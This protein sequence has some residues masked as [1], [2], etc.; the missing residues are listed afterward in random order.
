MSEIATLTALEL[1]DA[2]RRGELGAREAAAHFLARIEELNPALGSFVT[3]TAERAM[4]AAAAADERHAAGVA[5]GMLH[6]MPLGYK[7]LL[8]VAGVPTGYGTAAFDPVVPE[9]DSPLVATLSRAGAISLGKTQVP[10]FGLSCHS[11]ND[12]APPARN[13]LDPALSAGGSSGGEA[14]AVASGMLPFG[15]GSDGGGSVRIPA[16]ACGLIGLKPGLGTIPSDVLDGTVDG[17]G[18]PKLTVSGPLARTAL[19]AALLMDAM[20]D[21][22]RET[23]LEALD[24]GAVDALRGLRIGVSTASPFASVYEIRLSAD[25]HVAL[26][27]GIKVLGARGHHLEEAEIFYDAAYPQ[28]FSTV[29]TGGLAAAP[30]PA[31]SEAKLGTLARSF[32][33]R[34]TAREAKTSVE[35][36]RR[37]TQ[38]AA[39][40]R[41][42][43]GR[44]DVVL[45]PAM[46]FAPPE[47]GFYTSQDADTDYMRQC[48]YTPFTSMVNVSGLP[49]ITVPTL[50][51]AGGLSMGVQLIGRTGSE[52]QLL[53]LA[54]QLSKM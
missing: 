42:Q 15:P 4:A 16:S 53:A 44:Y 40:F 13:P 8:D 6:G 2:L 34:A 49:A 47:I 9:K 12:V 46:A 35:A 5:P 31:G 50:T 3:V 7:D 51:T 52:A 27:R 48:Q 14:A 45:T 24:E 33:E 1:R 20:V 25:A 37:L 17:F 39:D 10:E 38:I 11:E 19:D 23:Y 41:T 30:I 21:P 22:T 36:A 18:A 28:T 26:N 54:E 29:W 32:R 43:W